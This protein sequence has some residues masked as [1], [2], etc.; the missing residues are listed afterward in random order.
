MTKFID[1]DTG[2]ISCKCIVNDAPRQRA[3]ERRNL[4]TSV[5]ESEIKLTFFLGLGLS[6]T[7][8]QFFV[9]FYSMAESELNQLPISLR[10][11][12]QRGTCK[13]M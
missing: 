13:L 12:R 1:A 4:S 10:N 3:F 7:Y 5:S 6:A 11:L 2:V 8:F 9:C